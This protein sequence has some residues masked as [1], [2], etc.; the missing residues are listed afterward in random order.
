[1]NCLPP[2]LSHGCTRHIQRLMATG[3]F[4]AAGRHAPARNPRVEHRHICRWEQAASIR[5]ACAVKARFSA[6]NTSD[7]AARTHGQ[8]KFQNIIPRL[9]VR[10]SRSYF[11]R[12]ECSPPVTASYTSPTRSSSRNGQIYER[13]AAENAS[14]F[15]FLSNPQ[16]NYV[17]QN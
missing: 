16:L 12:S 4:L 6:A 10:H 5:E 1:M 7:S 9:P 3:L 14:P 11:I 17:S 2:A 13:L 8:Q 15:A